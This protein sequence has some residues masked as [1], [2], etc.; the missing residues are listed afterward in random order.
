MSRKSNT[1]RYPGGRGVNN[2]PPRE[3]ARRHGRIRCSMLAC[4]HGEVLD[5]SA[6]GFR[7]RS[8]TEVEMELG[9]EC[10]LTLRVDEHSLDVSA[11]SIW[12]RPVAQGQGT[13]VGFELL[14]MDSATRK[15]L[16]DLVSIAKMS[17]GLVRGWSPMFN[18]DEKAA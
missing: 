2:D 7:V 8:E 10:T 1:E 6:S 13:E 11:K 17:E 4:E 14:S 5:L 3:N 9:K 16:L 18:A 15:R 12:I